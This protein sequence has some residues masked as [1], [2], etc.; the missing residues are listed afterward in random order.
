MEMNGPTTGKLPG[1]IFSISVT[2]IKL[3]LENPEIERIVK[4][5]AT[6]NLSSSSVI[7]V[8][9]IPYIDSEGQQ[10][11]RIIIVLT[12]SSTSSIQGEAALNT[13]VQIQERLLHAGESRFPLVEYATE[14]ELAQS[15][16]S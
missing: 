4:S 2:K 6:A 7:S 3:M 13:L 12:P 1:F 11:L 15:G 9:S 8:R 14:A 10:A 16:D 5:T